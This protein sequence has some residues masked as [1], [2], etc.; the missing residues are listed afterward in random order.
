MPKELS[1]QTK[2]SMILITIILFAVYF[3]TRQYP[4]S[5]KVAT[6]T[7]T[8]S[9]QEDATNTPN[10]VIVNSAIESTFKDDLPKQLFYGAFSIHGAWT[11]PH[12]DLVSTLNSV[13]MI[14]LKESKIC[15]L[16]QANFMKWDES[17]P[18]INF[19]NY[20]TT[21]KILSWDSDSGII[22]KYEGD[23]SDCQEDLLEINKSGV[24]LIEST[25]G[26]AHELC[27]KDIKPQ[28]LELSSLDTELKY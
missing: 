24:T 23:A 7:S 1:K 14:C 10:R 5:P 13:D 19:T 9:T 4:T 11:A 16:A 15:V 28:L 25:K 22:A 2:V 8:I 6:A 18:E 20:I 27:P 3:S 17:G 21:Y 12:G 26:D